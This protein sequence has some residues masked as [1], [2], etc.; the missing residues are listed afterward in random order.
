M[1]T[2]ESLRRLGSALNVPTDYLL[3]LVDIPGLVGIADIVGL[4]I[5][6]LSNSDRNLARKI[7]QMLLKRNQAVHASGEELRQVSSG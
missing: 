4:D 7:V 6:R 3:G 2:I 5:D 1:P